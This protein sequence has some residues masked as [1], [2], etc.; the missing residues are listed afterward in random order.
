MSEEIKQEDRLARMEDAI[1]RLE[2]LINDVID[3][4][5][6]VYP[7][8]DEPYPDDGHVDYYVSIPVTG[9]NGNVSTIESVSSSKQITKLAFPVLEVLDRLVQH[10]TYFTPTVKQLS[11]LSGYSMSEPFKSFIRALRDNEMVTVDNEQLVKPTDKG[12]AA[13]RRGGKMPYNDPHK[14]LD[15]WFTRIP[16]PQ[17]SIIEAMIEGKLDKTNTYMLK[18]LHK[19]ALEAGYDKGNPAFKNLLSKLKS[20]GLIEIIEGTTA[21]V[22][23]ALFMNLL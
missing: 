14:A 1:N 18:S 22:T 8:S 23:P 20:N 15:E 17:Q 5:N 13:V 4:L 6:D 10:H 7:V 21:R 3:I 19:I 16:R 12:I 9:A 11:T 2:G